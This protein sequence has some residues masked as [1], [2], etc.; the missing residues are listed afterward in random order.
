MEEILFA[1]RRPHMLTV[2]Y[3]IVALE[4]EQKKVRWNFSSLQKYIRN[5]IRNFRSAGGVDSEQLVNRISQF[6]QYY[7]Q[8]RMA[9]FL[10]PVLRQCTHEADALLDE[11]EKLN[12]ASVTL[13]TSLRQR[14]QL[15]LTKGA[16][17]IEELCA[18]LE[19]C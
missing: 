18:S 8:R 11:L 2:T 1:F 6:E 12:V 7:Q 9:V 4:L 10:I 14:L 5:S 19:Q 15:A 3:S 13:V 16:A 17:M